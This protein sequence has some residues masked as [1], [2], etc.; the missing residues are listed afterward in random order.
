MI[1]A[2]LVTR[3]FMLSI[4]CPSKACLIINPASGAVTATELSWYDVYRFE[5]PLPFCRTIFLLSFQIC[6][7][8]GNDERTEHSYRYS[9]PL[10]IKY[11]L[12]AFVIKFNIP[13]HFLSLGQM[14][15]YSSM[16]GVLYCKPHF[17]QLFKESGNFSKNFHTGNLI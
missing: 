2:R 15:N 10:L 5:I 7:P 12:F 14:S 13:F 11:S 8:V 4:S 9:R 17:E 6:L 3:P 16:D 1:N